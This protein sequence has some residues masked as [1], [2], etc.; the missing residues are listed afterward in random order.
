MKIHSLLIAMVVVGGFVSQ[1]NACGYGLFDPDMETACSGDE[2]SAQ[3]AL[4]RLL[5]RG[6]KALPG[7]QRYLAQAESTGKS[8][9]EYIKRLRTGERELT[10]ERREQEIERAEK[11]LIWN[12][13]R[14]R[15]AKLIIYMLNGNEFAIVMPVMNQLA[16]R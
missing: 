11:Y 12:E 5:F 3:A 1:S 8:Y 4:T 6:N 7:A 14:I 16:S 13:Q 15:K 10:P 9:Q 2:R